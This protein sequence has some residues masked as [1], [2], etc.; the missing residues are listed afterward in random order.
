MNTDIWNNIVTGLFV[1]K[2]GTYIHHS[3]Y[4]AASLHLVWTTMLGP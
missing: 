4:P 2:S 1:L 3:G